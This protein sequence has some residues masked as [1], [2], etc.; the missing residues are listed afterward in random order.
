MAC[1]S[2]TAV[3]R[4]CGT[5]IT[6]GS[7]RLWMVAFKD[8]YRISGNNVYTVGTSSNLVTAVG[9]TGSIKYQE[10]GFLR[11]SAGFDS[12][13]TLDPTK[14]VAFSTNTLTLKLGDLS[15]TNQL[16]LETIMAQPVSAILKLRT[17]NYY[18]LGL[19]GQLQ[20]NGFQATSG[21][22]SGDE[23]SYTLTFNEI[24]ST[25]PR[26]IDPTYISSITA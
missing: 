24:D 22:S 12:T 21:K 4:L 16:F 11:D 5:N 20:M 9:L 6:P 19:N 18:V 17:G 25:V 2:I 1:S 3:S 15:V 23:V 14:G 7:E 10:I 13:G 8:F 26:G